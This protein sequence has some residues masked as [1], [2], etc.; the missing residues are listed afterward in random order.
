V[1]RL[2]PLTLALFVLPSVALATGGSNDETERL[3]R[4]D[5]TLA[6]QTA[7]RRTDLFTGWRLKRSG[8]PDDDDSDFPCAFDPDLSAFVITGKHQTT[9][10]HGTTGS[11]LVST[12]GVFRHVRDAAGDFRASAK[13]G[14]LPCLRSA[15]LAGLRQAN[16]RARITSSRMSTTPRVGAQ[17]VSYRVVATTYPTKRLPSFKVYTDFL[18]FRQGRSQATLLFTALRVPVQGQFALARLVQSRMK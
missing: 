4:A 9:F 6:K 18:A 12:V 8:L 1:K 7:V 17:S 11:Q 14:L 2:A 13:P 3:N 5:M 16:L 15:L 10:S